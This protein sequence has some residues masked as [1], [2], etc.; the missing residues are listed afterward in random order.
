MRSTFYGL[1]VARSGL[2][3]SQNELNV[4][5]HNIANVDTVGYT[6]QRLNTAAKPPLS[7]NVQ[8]A[9]DTRAATGRG[10]EA[11]TVDQVRNLFTD[12]KYRAEA[13]NTGYWNTKMEE[14]FMVQQLYDSVLEQKSTSSSIFSALNSFSAALDTLVEKPSGLAE[15]TNV[16][17]KAMQLT[18]TFQYTYKKLEEHHQNLNSTIEVTVGQINNIAESIANLN[19][20]IFGYE[21]TGAKANDLRDSRNLLLDQLSGLVDIGY[22]ENSQ[23]HL[24][25][26]IGGR[27]L[28]DGVNV[29]KL[30]VDPRGADNQLDVIAGLPANLIRKQ[31]S[32]VW[33]DGMGKP[34]K[35]P[36]D[37]VLVQGGSLQAYLELRDGK[38]EDTYGI[39]FVAHRLNELARKVAKEI[40]DVHRQGWTLPFLEKDAT[41]T[42]GLSSLPL[43]GSTTGERY[44]PSAQGM[45]FFQVGL[46]DDYSKITAGNFQVS[47]DIQNN[48]HLIAA[49]SEQLDVGGRN[50]DGS[51]IIPDNG[52]R[53]NAENLLKMTALFAKKDAAGNP[54][55]YGDDL[56]LLVANVG[57]HQEKLKVMESAQQVRIAAIVQQ[58]KSESA[59]GIDEELTNMVRF[60]HAYNANSRIITAIDEELDTLINRMGTVGR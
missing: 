44:Y 51:L 20:Q 21:L 27:A 29:N 4:T 47:E 49:S 39:P 5:G 48:V 8:F 52:L 36:D 17:T 43:P 41:A 2:Y 42:G 56:K 34:S 7:M 19:R 26:T 28:V 32:I 22:Y 16:M 46:D 59:V 3:T 9:M 53:G 60:T 13:S 24:A 23:G 18:E 15:R 12:A 50:P 37:R 10:V 1:E 30:A 33:A 25:V 58:R 57:A 38:T 54:D 31:N 45:N 11:L 55:N 14:F 40:N 35:N 6:R